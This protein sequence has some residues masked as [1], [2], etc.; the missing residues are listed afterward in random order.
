METVAGVARIG[1]SGVERQA[2]GRLDAFRAADAFAVAAVKA[3]AELGRSSCPELAVEIRRLVL[4]GG[5]ALVAATC[6]PPGS[7]D[8][9][10]LLA[11]ARDRLAEA[12]YALYLSRRLG[13]IDRRRYRALAA[14]QDA[15][16]RE[17]GAL[18][19]SRAGPN[20]PP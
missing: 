7:A 5:G 19:P 3:A 10:A 9:L 14:Q 1:S 8:E 20:R 12:R 11:A 4:R 15:A 6:A 16:L 18:L 13:A 17:V 2:G